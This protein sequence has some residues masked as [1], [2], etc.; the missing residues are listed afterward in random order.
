M[1]F[2]KKISENK[3]AITL[4]KYN[5]NDLRVEPSVELQKNTR[6][7]NFIHIC[8]IDLETTGTHKKNDEIIEI[9]MKVI[10]IDKN[11]GQELQAIAEYES[12]QDPGFPI[13][14][15]ASI[16]NNITD[17]M[18]VDHQID[19]KKVIELLNISQLCVAHNA[20]FDRAFLDRKLDESKNKIWACSI[21]DINW[22]E[23]GFT[24]FK[25]ELLAHWH[26][27]YYT[28]HRAMYDVDAMIH[29]VVHPS[30]EDNKPI[31]EL[32]Q[33]ARVPQFRMLV[34]FNYKKELV[35]L[36]KSKRYG[37]NG[38]TKEWSRIIPEDQL[39]KEKQWLSENIYN[40]TFAGLVEKITLIDKYKNR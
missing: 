26:G 15:E 38:D 10:K 13:P 40:G 33:N 21:N 20:S 24:N 17:E 34:K 37:F 2:L 4:Y 27:F 23:R 12:F 14:K 5:G 11:T 1:S 31:N 35:N 22:I 18:V 32:I 28:S 9:A 16:V 25:Q 39:E 6:D 36:I 3:Q 19:W 30:Y 29:L 8:F 7:S